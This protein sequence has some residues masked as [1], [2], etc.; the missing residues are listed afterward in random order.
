MTAPPTVA[1][2]PNVEAFALPAYC[3]GSGADLITVTNRDRRAAG[4]A[5]LCPN[6]RL[7][8]LA[9]QWADHL[10]ATSTFVHQD[11]WSA[12]DTTPFYAMAENILRAPGPIT[13]DQMEVLWMNSPEHRKNILNPSYVAVG[14]GIART[15]QGVT[16]AVVEFGGMPR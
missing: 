10:A 6:S 13:I 5:P 7:G 8:H 4:L 16:Y 3:D 2:A 12:I 15:A 1:P 11:L 14:V 9:Q